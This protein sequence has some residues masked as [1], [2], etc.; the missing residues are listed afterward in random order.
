MKKMMKFAAMAVAL[1]AFFACEEK[2]DAPLTID[3]K[4]WLCEYVD[5]TDELLPAVVDLGVTI[6]GKCILAYE[7]NGNMEECGFVPICDYTVEATDATSGVITLNIDWGNGVVGSEKYSYSNLTETSVTFGPIQTPGPVEATKD[8][9][10][11]PTFT[12]NYA[13]PATLA[14]SKVEITLMEE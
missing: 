11:D 5:W 12:I 9:L 10:F 2:E 3:G 13:K 6:E 8:Q 1:F 4:Q 14:T 7:W